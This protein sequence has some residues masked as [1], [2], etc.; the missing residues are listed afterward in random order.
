MQQRLL[1]YLRKAGA[2]SDVFPK[3]RLIFS[4]VYH[5]MVWKTGDLNGIQK[6]PVV[7]GAIII[8][9]AC[10]SSDPL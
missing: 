3:M 8:K 9:Q 10:P 1:A 7:K 6:L 2:L 4:Y 5:V